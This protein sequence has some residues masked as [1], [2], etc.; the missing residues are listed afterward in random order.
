MWINGI[1]KTENNIK[2]K[3]IYCTRIAMSRNKLETKQLSVS[4]IILLQDI[5]I[6]AFK[7]KY[8]VTYLHD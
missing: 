1:H 2:I 6:N 8:W 7:V 5:G 3:K 4:I